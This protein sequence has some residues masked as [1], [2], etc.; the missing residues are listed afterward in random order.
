MFDKC[1]DDRIGSVLD[2]DGDWAAAFGFRDAVADTERYA[3]VAHRKE[4]WTAA[5]LD[6]YR[7]WRISKSDDVVE[8]DCVV[9]G[10]D[11]APFDVQIVAVGV[12]DFGLDR[13]FS[14][15]VNALFGRRFRARDRR[16][17]IGR[18][19][20]GPPSFRLTCR[21]AAVADNDAPIV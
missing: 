14:T 2:G 7:G 21:I 10:I 19:Q 1:Q 4:E 6:G 8:N 11:N 18:S 12:K 13:E 3:T 5:E 15:A 17:G 20:L 16:T 9:I